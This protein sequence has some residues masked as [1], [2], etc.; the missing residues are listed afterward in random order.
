MHHPCLALPQCRNR[1][2]R[3]DKNK[4]V[5][6]ASKNQKKFKK[7]FEDAVMEWNAFV[8]RTGRNDV[9]KVEVRQLVN[10][11]DSI[12]RLGAYADHRLEGVSRFAR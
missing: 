10:Q 8:D 1:R 3:I 6:V 4:T 2:G 9:K 11:P 7:H 12:L 5:K